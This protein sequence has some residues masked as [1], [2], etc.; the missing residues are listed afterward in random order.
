MQ[1][2]QTVIRP[3][4]GGCP[5]QRKLELLLRLSVA[6]GLQQGCCERLPDWIIPIRRFR[7]RQGILQVSRLLELDDGAA[8]VAFTLCHASHDHGARDTKHFLYRYVG[9]LQELE[10]ELALQFLDRIGRRR[11]A[12]EVAL[13]CQRHARA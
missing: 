1:L 7:I 8:L 9:F 6:T 13:R 10:V 12:L 3:A 4:V 11:C 5:P 2:G